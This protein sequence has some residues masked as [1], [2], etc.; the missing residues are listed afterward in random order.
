[1]AWL[2]AVRGLD[3]AGEKRT[4]VPGAGLA[5][6]GLTFFPVAAR[7]SALQTACC[8]QSWKR[9]NFTW[10]L[11]D[12]SLS[13]PVIRSLLTDATLAELTERER[14]ARGVFRL[15]KA[16]IRR[17]DQ[18]GYGIIGAAEPVPPARSARR[19]GRD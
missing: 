11:W 17:T 2:P 12:V 6:L 18:G 15:L 5:F 9:G 10:L 3:P 1:L 8:D 19:G 16:P 14:R 7:D 4:G 13:A